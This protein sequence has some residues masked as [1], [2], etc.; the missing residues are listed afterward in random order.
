[1][2]HP[3]SDSTHPA[4]T[5]AI[6]GRPKVTCYL[7][8]AYLRWDFASYMLEPQWTLKKSKHSQRLEKTKG[9]YQNHEKTNPIRPLNDSLHCQGVLIV[10][11][12]FALLHQA[13][14]RASLAWEGAI[15]R[16]GR[17]KA[18]GGPPKAPSCVL[19]LLRRSQ[20]RTETGESGWVFLLC[21]N[22]HLQ[23]A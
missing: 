11:G 19:L 16:N 4:K 10:T 15:F 5:L 18:M 20:V 21:E 14:V 7:R 3:H 17:R 9:D 12:E 8:P 23:G 1:M 6:W 13:H 2:K 22:R